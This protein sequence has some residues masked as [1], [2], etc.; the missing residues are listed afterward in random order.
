MASP[1][2]SPVPARRRRA[3]RGFL[4]SIV[5]AGILLASLAVFAT[6]FVVE[7]SS[8]AATLRPGELLLV[9]RVTPGLLGVERG[10]VVIFHPPLSGYAGE[11]FVKRVIGLPGEH[12]VIHDGRVVVNDQPLEEPYVFKGEATTTAQREFSLTVPP[13][14]VFVLGDHRADSWDSRGYGPVPISSIVGRAWL[15]YDPTSS[16]AAVASPD[17][18]ASDYA[19]TASR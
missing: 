19:L 7:H 13:G 12:V 16:I 15:A 1:P 18:P 3:R 5:V 8:M 11:P 6:P 4:A 10:E 17:Y 2:P 14:D 9:D